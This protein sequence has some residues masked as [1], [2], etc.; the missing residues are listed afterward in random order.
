MAIGL[1]RQTISKRCHHTCSEK[2]KKKK[3]S[4]NLSLKTLH[5]FPFKV[6]LV[7]THK[8]QQRTRVPL[9][10][11]VQLMATKCMSFLHV[12]L[13]RQGGHFCF[14]LRP[15]YNPRRDVETAFRLPRNGRRRRNVIKMQRRWREGERE[16]IDD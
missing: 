10:N 2:R 7:T 13:C 15:L 6:L 12:S 5:I 1:H 8:I 3:G 11:S 9:H 16:T 4:K 14:K